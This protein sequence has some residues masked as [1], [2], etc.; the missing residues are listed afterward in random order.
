MALTAR[1]FRVLRARRSRILSRNEICCSGGFSRFSTEFCRA[2]GA[3]FQAIDLRWGVSEQ[4][5]R[6]QQ[7]IN[8]CLTEIARCRQTSPR[9]NFIVL[10][11]DRYGWVPAAWPNPCRRI[12]ADPRAGP[13]NGGAE[14]ARAVVSA[15]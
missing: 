15:R 5:S 2:R 1:T 3:N 12:R 4:A 11:G 8:I 7:A 13:R 9:P 14:I 6:D 10:L